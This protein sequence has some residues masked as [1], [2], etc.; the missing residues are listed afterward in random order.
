VLDVQPNEERL[1]SYAIDLGTEV[2]PQNGPGTSKLTS[3]KAVKGI[4]TTVTKNREEKTYR[5]ANRSQQD[6]T[7]LIEHAN[8]TNQQFK[9]VDTDK[10]VEDTKGVYRFSTSVKAGE[11]K[12]FTVKEER[13]VSTTIALSNSSDDQIR[14]FISLNE[15]TPALKEKLTDALKLKGTWDNQRR[16]LAQVVADLQRLSADQDRI[17]KNLANTPKEAEVYQTYLKKLSDQEKE[18]DGL[19]AK[20][21]KLMADE[22]AAKKGYEDYLANLSD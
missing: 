13:D 18:I 1:V 21:K 15:A 22:F 3:V 10:P 5:I 17:R 7:L 2:D 19:T 16:E 4:V 20:Q 12:K 8:R 9:L 14:Y 6:R 11:E